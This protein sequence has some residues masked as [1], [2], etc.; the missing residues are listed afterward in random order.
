M[1][2][3]KMYQE[4]VS[5]EELKEIEVPEVRVYTRKTEEKEE[6]IRNAIRESPEVFFHRSPIIVARSAESGRLFLADGAD[7]LR[8]AIEEKA[9]RVMLNIEEYEKD[10]EAYEAAQDNSYRLNEDRGD[11]V[12]YSLVQLVKERYK[13][14]KTVKEIATRLGKSE[15]HIRN[16]LAVAKDE[17]L[18]KPLKEEKI[19]LFDAIRAAHDPEL[20]REILNK[21]LI[22]SAEVEKPKFEEIESKEER[23]VEIEPTRKS[24]KEIS[25]RKP[26]FEEIYNEVVG[27]VEEKLGREL[28]G[29][30]KSEMKTILEALNIKHKEEIKFILVAAGNIL[31]KEKSEIQK[32]A[33]WEWKKRVEESGGWMDVSFE[34]VLE[35]VKSEEKARKAE[36]EVVRE[37]YREPRYREP[38][39][40]FEKPRAVEFEKPKPTIIE[41]AHEAEARPVGEVAPAPTVEQLQIEV[42]DRIVREARKILAVSFP[43]SGDPWKV[44]IDER[45]REMYM[46]AG[47][48]GTRIVMEKSIPRLKEDAMSPVSHKLFKRTS[49]F[50]PRP[51]RFDDPE[52]AEKVVKN[53]LE[54]YN[55]MRDEVVKLR[56]RLGER[57]WEA[58][59]RTLRDSTPI[60]LEDGRVL[61]LSKNP[62][63]V[64][65]IDRDT[66]LGPTRLPEVIARLKEGN[67]T[68]TDTPSLAT[69]VS[70][71]EVFPEQLVGLAGKTL[72][73]A[74]IQCPYCNRVA[75][76]HLTGLPFV[77]ECGWPARSYTSSFMKVSTG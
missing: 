3:V 43:H 30:I 27:E 22:I 1:G 21:A 28:S 11:V 44:L 17:E 25:A 48:V 41:E 75:R 12:A 67:C 38:K 76:D 56:D 32:K 74:T 18:M 77:C 58:L 51:K 64:I 63:V 37:V 8:I 53:I 73:L 47:E 19:T 55:S 33:L 29:T 61:L 42:M 10:S 34:D 66:Y 35:D 71:V 40:R 4:W 65:G 50:P 7:R 54:T 36:R 20:R 13:E 5:W 46:E 2:L 70:I 69:K 45:L 26:R 39:P 15:Q 14:G 6:S 68:I 49:H 52:V 72:K 59:A 16:I 23:I 9:P 31:G 62:Q 57:V 60:L 24:T